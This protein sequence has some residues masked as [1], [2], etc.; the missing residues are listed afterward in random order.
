MT[1]LVFLEDDPDLMAATWRDPKRYLWLLGLI[2]PTLPFIAYGLVQ[3][4]GWPIMWWVGPAV[5]HLC[6][7]LKY[8]QADLKYPSRRAPARPSRR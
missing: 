5:V 2:V 6:F 3:L 8:R 7:S 4:T 1:A